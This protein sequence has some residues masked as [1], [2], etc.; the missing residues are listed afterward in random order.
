MK[1]KSGFVKR[2]VAGMH[3]AVSADPTA[4]FDGII[5]LNAT[6]SFMFDMLMNGTTKEELLSGILSEYE[7]GKDKAEKDIDSFLSTLADNNLLETE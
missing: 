4:E 6:A 2:E 7:I 3:I 5:K 1:I